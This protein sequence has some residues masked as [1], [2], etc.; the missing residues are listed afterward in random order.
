MRHN[1]FTQT[2]SLHPS[3]PLWAYLNQP[4]F[5]RYYKTIWHPQKFAY[6]H[7]IAHLNICWYQEVIQGLEKCWHQVYV[8]VLLGDVLPGDVLA[9]DVLPEENTITN[10]MMLS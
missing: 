10:R 9:G 1:T 5:N 8:E 2:G 6:Q 3:F 7:Y 4:V